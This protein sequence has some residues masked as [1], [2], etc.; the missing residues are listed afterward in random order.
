MKKNKNLRF[1][2]S[3]VIILILIG[4]VII[5]VVLEGYVNVAATEKHSKLVESMLRTTMEN[6]VR[7]HAKDIKVPDT[8]NLNDPKLAR[9]F[10]G[11]YNAACR[12]CHGAPGR[13][14]DQW[15]FTYPAAPDLTDKKVVGRWSDAELYWI[16]KNGIKSTGMMALGPTHPEKAI[17]GVT[18]MVK[19]LPKMTATEYDAMEKW[20]NE[21]KE[22]EAAGMHH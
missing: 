16:I 9:Q 5:T 7:R 13:K 17:W 8:P 14:P 22:K 12:T 15:M 19:Q 20:F 1:I 3:G 10:Y 21:N 6:S 18:A 4:G 11:H 2:I